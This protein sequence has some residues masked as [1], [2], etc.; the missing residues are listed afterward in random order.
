VPA[1]ASLAENAVGYV[2]PGVAEGLGPALAAVHFFGAD[3][4]PGDIELH[5]GFSAGPPPLGARALEAR[6]PDV[7]GVILGA[8][9]WPAA[10]P[11]A[12]TGARGR[13][14]VRVALS[15]GARRAPLADPVAGLAENALTALARLLTGLTDART[16]ALR[17]PGLADAAEDMTIAEAQHFALSGFDIDAVARARGLRRTRSADPLEAMEALWARPGLEVLG[18]EANDEQ[19]RRLPTEA[20][21]RLAVYLVPRMRARDVMERLAAHL[22]AQVPSLIVEHESHVDPWRAKVH[23]PL[24]EAVREAYRAGFG[25]RAAFVRRAEPLPEATAYARGLGVPLACAATAGPENGVGTPHEQIEHTRLASAM[26]VYAALL[27]GW[28]ARLA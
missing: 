9:V 8:G 13:L 18:I 25:T 7:D 19:G 2:G 24:A 11:A 6:A 12:I 22:V 21:A 4:P 15:T 16:G 20:R 26:T 3:V 1:G 5:L 27:E 10:R 14:S 28:A 23:G 17:V